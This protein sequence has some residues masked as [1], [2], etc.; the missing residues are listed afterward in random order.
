MTVV[1]NLFNPY[2][3][4]CSAEV[5]WWASHDSGLLVLGEEGVEP[6][7]RHY[8]GK[9]GIPHDVAMENW[10]DWALKFVDYMFPDKKPKEIKLRIRAT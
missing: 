9:F 3:V 2:Q 8:T 1:S 10:N 4:P 7:L 6:H 5:E